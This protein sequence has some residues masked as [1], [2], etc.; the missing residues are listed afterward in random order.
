MY[1]KGFERKGLFLRMITSY[2]LNEI[3][4]LFFPNVGVLITKIVPFALACHFLTKYKVHLVAFLLLTTICKV[5]SCHKDMIPI[6]LWTRLELFVQY[7]NDFH[8]YDV[9][10]C[11]FLISGLELWPVT[12]ENANMTQMFHATS[13]GVLLHSNNDSKL[14]IYL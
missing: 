3:Q 11:L 13:V 12:E 8:M 9:I 5:K 10:L 7:S 1:I 6:F 14:Q 4:Y 2:L